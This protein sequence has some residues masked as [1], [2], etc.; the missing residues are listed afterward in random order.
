MF[1]N[2]KLFKLQNH[3][4]KMTLLLIIGLLI[5]VAL[6]PRPAKADFTELST[7]GGY[8][9]NDT[10]P[11]TSIIPYLYYNSNVGIDQINASIGMDM[12]STSRVNRIELWDSDSSSR[13]GQANYTLY[14]S[15]ENVNKQAGQKLFTLQS[16]WSLTTKIVNNRL[17]HVFKFSG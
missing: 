8:L 12:G 14:T 10:D 11:T 4:W 3:K 15:N 13:V 17:V 1:I 9:F 6:Y 5:A 16:G 2:L 7:T